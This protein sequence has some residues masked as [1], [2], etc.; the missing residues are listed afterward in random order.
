M[1]LT[2]LSLFYVLVNKKTLCGTLMGQKIEYDFQ[3]K[4]T[5]S[6]VC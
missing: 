4:K 1:V 3:F 5:P 2:R 6:N